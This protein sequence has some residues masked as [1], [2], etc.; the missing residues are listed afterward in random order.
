MQKVNKKDII[1]AILVV[2]LG[3]AWLLNVLKIIPT[4]DWIWVGGLG[5]SGLLIMAFGGK[6]KL[7]FVA[8]PLLLIASITSVLRQKE[9][10]DLDVEVPILTII[11]GILLLIVHLLGLPNSELLQDKDDLTAK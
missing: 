5:L 8:G 4:V 11:L 1:L 3:T 9:V 10:F 6:N 2:G 7:T